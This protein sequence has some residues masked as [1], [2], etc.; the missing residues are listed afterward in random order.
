ME[1]LICSHS[2]IALASLQNDTLVVECQ[3]Q[4][5]TNN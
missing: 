4:V 5:I 2:V 1:V 3:F